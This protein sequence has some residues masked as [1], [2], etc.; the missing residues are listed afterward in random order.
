MLTIANNGG[1]NLV[2]SMGYCGGGTRSREIFDTIPGVQQRS[3]TCTHDLTE[4]YWSDAGN[5]AFDGFGYPSVKVGTDSVPVNML[6]GQRSY[7]IGGYHCTVRNSFA[8]N[9]IYRMVIEPQT[10]ENSSRSDITINL[11]GNMGSDGSET[12][13]YDSVLV[14]TKW[15]RFYINTESNY[16][17]YDPRV[18][19]MIVPSQANQKD[20]VTYWQPSSGYVAMRARNISLPATV[21]IIPSYHNI[22]S[23]KVWM[24]KDLRNSAS[25]LH[26][27]VDTGTTA[28][29]NVSSVGLT[30]N[31][32]GLVEGIYTDTLRITHNGTNPSTPVT[33]PIV[34]R[35]TEGIP[36]SYS[37]KI[38]SIGP[39]VATKVSGT[40]FSIS[41]LKVG[42]G[43]TGRAAGTR[44]RVRLW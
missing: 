35:V 28:G 10:G 37:Y 42:S 12:V 44:Y 40:Q 32:T 31:A 14:G 25:W 3:F 7:T 13:R 27:S 24:Q 36:G 41:N 1:A 17:N 4:T 33:V 11:S 38:L 5:D 23:I 8:E 22:D 34:L 21:Y 26:A 30:F 9:H 15:L 2:W 20:S 16:P 39:S 18:V 19:F 43:V 6:E 29:G